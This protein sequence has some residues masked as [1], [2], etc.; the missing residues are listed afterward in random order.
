MLIVCT[1]DHEI[2]AAAQDPQKHAA[3]WGDLVIVPAH[4]S[5]SEATTVM[6]RSLRNVEGPLCFSAHGNDTHIGDAD[7][8]PRDWGWSCRQIA[9]ILRDRLPRNFAGPI[10]IH[11][12]ATTVANFSAGLAVELSAMRVFNGL[13][14]YGYNKALPSD[15]GFP[16]PGKLSTN[17][18][19]QETQVSFQE[20]KVAQAAA[21]AVGGYRVSFAGGY[22]VEVPRGFDAEETSR[23]LTLL[24]ES[25]LR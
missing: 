4:C 11:A 5:Q 14:I 20:A 18:E 8:G 24:A 2:V 25:Q 19:L 21:A 13:W 6:E 3:R 1:K 22:T 17:A 15:A 10:L 16:D 23:F 9:L 7:N 12:C